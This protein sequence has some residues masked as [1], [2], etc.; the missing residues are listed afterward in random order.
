MF[1]LLFAVLL[2]IDQVTKYLVSSSM[3]LGQS[4]PLI[5]GVFRLTYVHNDGAAFSI[6]QGQR[7]FFVV[8]TLIALVAIVFVRYKYYKNDKWMTAALAVLAAGALGN[9]LDRFLYGYVVDFFDFYLINFAVFNFAD[10]CIVV[11]LIFISILVLKTP[12]KGKN[13]DAGRLS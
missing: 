5:E 2:V 4:F 12:S 1:W 9:L 10:C 13:R 8:I 11:S 7:W 6:L 3:E